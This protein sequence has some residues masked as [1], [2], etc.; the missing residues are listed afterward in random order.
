M[1]PL[2]KRSRLK[3]GQKQKAKYPRPIPAA[4]DMFLA[5]YIN[6]CIFYE[7]YPSISQE[8]KYLGFVS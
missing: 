1:S 5:K 7:F 2:L 4:L 3:F 6:I 8:L